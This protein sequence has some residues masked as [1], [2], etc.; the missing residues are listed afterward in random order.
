MVNSSGATW[1]NRRG[2]VSTG[3]L[4]SLL[5]FVAAGY[6]GVGIGS[7]YLKYWQLLDEM[8]S[9]ARL[10]PGLNDDVIRRR[11]VTRAEELDLPAQARRF[12]IRRLARSREIVIRTSWQERLEVPFYAFVVTLSPEA[13]AQL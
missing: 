9:Q 2:K 4:L 5:L 8:R 13:R 11:L 10:A 12:T 1:R 3:C 7:T 6:Y